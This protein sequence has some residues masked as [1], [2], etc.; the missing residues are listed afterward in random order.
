ML[1][2]RQ[3]CQTGQNINRF[4]HLVGDVIGEPLPSMEYEARLQ[5]LLDHR[6][7]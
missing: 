7:G 2:D 3:R 5:A 1:C 6:V 4:W